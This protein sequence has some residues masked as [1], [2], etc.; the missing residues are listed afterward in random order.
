MAANKARTLH[1]MRPVRLLFLTTAVLGFCRPADVACA[2]IRAYLSAPERIPPGTTAAVSALII[3]TGGDDAV[4]TYKLDSSG[5]AIEEGSGERRVWLARRSFFALRWQAK[6]EQKGPGRLTLLLDGQAV[7]EERF[8]VADPPPPTAVAVVRELSA[9]PFVIEMPEAGKA[10]T[11]A[12]EVVGG[13]VGE[14]A[15]TLAGL[16]GVRGLNPDAL[17]AR[18]L[19]PAALGKYPA[20]PELDILPALQDLS[21]G[22]GREPGW[23]PDT[24]TTSWAIFWLGSLAKRGT[25]IDTRVL[26]AGI[27]H[28]RRRLPDA[29]P[30]MLVRGLAALAA[31]DA[32]QGA[33][34]EMFQK[35]DAA[36]LSQSGRLLGALAGASIPLP[37]QAEWSQLNTLETAVLACA[38]SDA[39]LAAAGEVLLRQLVVRRGA[40]PSFDTHEAPLCALALKRIVDAGARAAEG[41]VAVS[42]DRKPCGPPVHVSRDEPVVRRQVQVAATPGVKGKLVIT[43]PVGPGVFCRAVVRPAP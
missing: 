21:G 32:A 8:E 43:G 31:A 28:L 6:A 5:A 37:P 36:H 7:V 22:W 23:G 11:V 12:L 39:Q 34:M 2:D 30:E 10:Y 35:T 41:R 1:K 27:D 3:N 4:V 25:N 33:D 16:R 17:I 14:L 19:V 15:A 26:N 18:G 24:R 42:L 13:A 20:Q 29:T 40:E 9:E 38:V